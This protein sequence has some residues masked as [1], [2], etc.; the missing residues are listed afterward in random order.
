M[1]YTHVSYELRNG[2][3]EVHLRGMA[4]KRDVSQRLSKLDYQ[5]IPKRQAKDLFELGNTEI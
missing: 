3:N 2:D 4:A 1:Y 5:I